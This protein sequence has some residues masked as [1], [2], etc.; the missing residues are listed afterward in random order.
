M[1]NENFIRVYDNIFAPEHCD[2]LISVFNEHIHD[3]YS[4]FE[5]EITRKDSAIAL[6]NYK[7]PQSMDVG[8]ATGQSI[9]VSAFNERLTE[10]LMFYAEEFNILKQIDFASYTIKVQKTEPSGGYH[11]WHCEQGGYPV[12]SRLFVWT[13]YLNDI[14]EG[15][16]TEFLYQAKRI[17]PKKGS[18]LFFPASYTHTH[19]GNPPLNATKYIATGWYNLKAE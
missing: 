14:D 17:K 13:V 6:G 9:L 1:T 7:K 10:A 18:V 19:R 15:G 4:Q 3:N 16:E 5:N 11:K 12:R 2:E 8:D